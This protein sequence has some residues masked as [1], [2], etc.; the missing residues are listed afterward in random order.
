MCSSPLEK[1]A[2]TACVMFKWFS[3]LKDKQQEMLVSEKWNTVEQ[4]H[5]N[6]PNLEEGFN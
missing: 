5:V 6:H 3:S 2:G 1:I 4:K